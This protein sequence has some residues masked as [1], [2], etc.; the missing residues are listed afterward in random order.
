MINCKQ[1]QQLGKL[2]QTEKIMHY[3]SD[4]FQLIYFNK[5]YMDRKHRIS[6]FMISL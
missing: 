4:I 6:I 3:T 2:K 1:K 5:F